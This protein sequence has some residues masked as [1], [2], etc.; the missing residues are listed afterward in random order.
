VTMV[1]ILMPVYNE[2]PTVEQAV[3]RVL[4]TDFPF[5]WELIM[6]DDGSTDG[7]SEIL[8]VVAE[9]SDRITLI[10]HERNQGKGTAIRTAVAA[11]AGEFSTILD[12]DLEYDPADIPALIAPLEEGLV[13]VA[14]GVRA[15]DGYSSHSYLYVLGNRGVTLAANVVFNVYLKDVM[16]CHKA[17]RTD[18]F[19][20]LP[21]QEPGFAV[22]P[23]IAARVIQR[24]ERI[25]EVPVSYIARPTEEGKKLT[26]VDGFRA[27]RTLV[28]C[29]LTPRG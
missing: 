6:V 5:D 9:K 13:D 10:S 17:M 22:E 12:A 28:R 20:A 24:G 16:T 18:L 4:D 21:L 26:A 15:F 8:P 3:Q 19:R 11:A 7:T 14:F 1:S 25:Y 29:R 27:L 2:A 23:E